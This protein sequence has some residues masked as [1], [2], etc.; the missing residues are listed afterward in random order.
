MTIRRKP[1][2]TPSWLDRPHSN[3]NLCPPEW[4]PN[5]AT[6]PIP[7][8]SAGSNP[9]VPILLPPASPSGASEVSAGAPSSVFEGGAVSDTAQTQ[10]TPDS[11]AT[12]ESLP[13]DASRAPG[14]P[15]APTPAKSPHRKSSTKRAAAVSEAAEGSPSSVSEGGAVRPRSSAIPPTKPDPDF[16]RRRCTICNHQD[17]ADIEAAF[18]NWQPIDRI[19]KNYN[20]AD[21][22]TVYRHANAFNLNEQRREHMQSALDLIIEDAGIVQT[23]AQDVIRAIE[24][25]VRMRGANVSPL[26]RYE[27]KYIGQKEPQDGEEKVN[28]NTPELTPPLTH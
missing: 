22:T 9:S 4:L 2:S 24:L 23:R 20:L 27:I 12:T 21:R 13:V 1:Y 15:A 28:R 7:T 18:L 11:A 5:R 14:Q 25:S 8:G 26:Y 19:V 6:G 16:H 17:R 3:A 10:P